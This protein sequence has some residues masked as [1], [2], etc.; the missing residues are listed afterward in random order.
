MR[1]R[2]F[3]P[4]FTLKPNGTGLGLTIVNEIVK[5][6]R[7]YIRVRPN[8]PRGTKFIIELPAREPAAVGEYKR[9]VNR[10]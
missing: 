9:T 10:S 4:G 3:E 2:I 1:A 7:G 8:E 6:H 5:D